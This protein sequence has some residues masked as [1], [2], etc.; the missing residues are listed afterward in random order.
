MFS[1]DM[2]HMEGMAVVDFI[3]RPLIPTL[4]DFTTVNLLNFADVF[5]FP[6]GGK[7][8]KNKSHQT[9]GT[10]TISNERRNANAKIYLSELTSHQ[11]NEKINR[12]TVF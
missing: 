11:Q 10:S 2:V 6:Q 7:F 8:R 5:F 1:L 9:F 4:H 3:C 12:F